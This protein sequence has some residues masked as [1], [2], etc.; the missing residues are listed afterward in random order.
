[1]IEQFEN[2]DL[3]KKKKI[4]VV[5]FNKVLNEF[6]GNYKIL[7]KEDLNNITD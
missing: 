4:T 1:L 7:A 3:H 2:F 6:F 5:Q